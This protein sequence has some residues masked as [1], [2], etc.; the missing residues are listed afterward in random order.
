MS[1]TNQSDQYHMNVMHGN[2]PHKG[3]G[4]DGSVRILLFFTGKARD[5]KI[6]PYTGTQMTKEKLLLKIIRDVRK[7]MEESKQ[8]ESEHITTITYLYRCFAEAVQ[9]SLMCDSY[10]GTMDKDQISVYD[11][12]DK[13]WG[14][15]FFAFITSC[16]EYLKKKRLVEV[17]P[18]L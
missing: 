4:C 12:K 17:P 11:F 3:P 1:R 18:L 5:S 14:D 2:H 10:D 6:E 8:D 7:K 16:G 13:V 9:E 15:F